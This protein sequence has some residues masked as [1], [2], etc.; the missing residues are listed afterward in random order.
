MKITIETDR[1]HKT[2]AECNGI[3]AESLCNPT[4]NFDLPK[5]VHMAVQRL[6]E[7]LEGPKEDTGLNVGDTVEV[8]GCHNEFLKDVVGKRGVVTSIDEHAR[9]K[10]EIKYEENISGDNK[11]W[12]Y[13]G[14]LKLISKDDTGFHVGDIVE[15]V[16][17]EA[18][19]S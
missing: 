1:H 3:T 10:Y 6:L 13:P 15:V 12:S 14:E 2:T 18:V 4:D 17:N 8:V 16:A 19:I 9:E 5:G 11:W 7:K